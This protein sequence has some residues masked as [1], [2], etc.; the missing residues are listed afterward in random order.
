IDLYNVP[1][2]VLERVYRQPDG[3]DGPLTNDYTKYEGKPRMVL[4]QE[5]NYMAVDCIGMCKYHTVF[6]SPNHPTFPEFAR[7]IYLNAG[8]EF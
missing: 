6:L 8:L 3:Y 1:M 4:W 5:M 2:E 7:L